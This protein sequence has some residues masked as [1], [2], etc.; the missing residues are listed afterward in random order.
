MDKYD[1]DLDVIFEEFNEHLVI[2]EGYAGKSTHTYIEDTRLGEVTDYLGNVYTYYE[3]SA[4]HLE[5]TSY[6]M[7]ISDELKEMI[8]WV[9]KENKTGQNPVSLKKLLK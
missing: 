2:P 8:D 3:P 6:A 4:I 5:E 7:S 1:G 9:W